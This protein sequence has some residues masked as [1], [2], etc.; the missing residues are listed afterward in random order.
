[1]VEANDNKKARKSRAEL[2]ENPLAPLRMGFHATMQSLLPHYQ[3]L[4]DMQ[5]DPTVKKDQLDAYKQQLSQAADQVF[6]EHQLEQ[7]FTQL[8][9]MVEADHTY[10]AGRFAEQCE[11]ARY[12]I[13]HGELPEDRW[14]RKP[15]LHLKESPA[16]QLVWAATL[17]YITLHPHVQEHWPDEHR[18][19]DKWDVASTTIWQDIEETP[20]LQRE[21]W[22]HAS[23]IA[24]NI[25]RKNTRVRWG[26]P[27]TSVQFDRQTETIDIDLIEALT[28]GVEHARAPVYREIGLSKLKIRWSERANE[29]YE[30]GEALKAKRD[31]AKKGQG[32]KPT[33][34]EFVEYSEMV[35]EFGAL[36]KVEYAAE[37]N[38][39]NQYAVERSR[40]HAND[41]SVNVVQTMLD[42]LSYGPEA[43]GEPQGEKADIAKQKLANVTRAMRMAFYCDNGLFDNTP[44][45]WK[46]VGVHPEWIEEDPTYRGA[47]GQTSAEALARIQQLC[48]QIAQAQPKRSAF[49]DHVEQIE[50]HMDRK[51]VW[52]MELWERYAKQYAEKLIEQAKEQAQQQMDQQNQQQDN[53]DEGEEQDQQ[54][55][56]QPQD[57][58]PQSGQGQSGS[59][60]GQQQQE[61][62]DSWP[63]EGQDD[64]KQ[65]PG[66]M[67]ETPPELGEEKGQD[68]EQGQDQNGQGQDGEGQDSGDQDGQSKNQQGQ[69]GDQRGKTVEELLEEMRE[70]EQGQEQDGQQQ[71]QQQG[72]DGDGQDGEG[73]QPGQ[74]GQE[75]QDGQGMQPGQ[76][77][78][79][80]GSQPGM[81]T[82]PSDQGGESNS[83]DDLPVGD[84]SNYKEMK[85]RYSGVI[86]Q[87]ERYLS[88]LKKPYRE[89]SISQSDHTLV[90]IGGQ[91]DRFNPKQVQRRREKILTRQQVGISDFEDFRNDESVENYVQDDVVIVVDFSS[92]MQGGNP[93]AGSMALQAA[94]IMREAGKRLGVDVKIFAFGDT[95]GPRVLVT[96]E[97]SDRQVGENLAK[98]QEKNNWGTKLKPAFAG[99]A[100]YPGINAV[101]ADRHNKNGNKMVG[102]THLL[103]ISDGDLNDKEEALAS[104]ENTLD[105]VPVMTTD[106][107][108]VTSKDKKTSMDE[109]ADE[110]QVKKAWQRPEVRR[111]INPEE[112]QKG[113]LDMLFSRIRHGARRDAIR[114]F[115]KTRMFDKAVKTA[116]FAERP[117][118][119]WTDRT[120]QSQTEA[121]RAR[122]A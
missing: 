82:M 43:V 80:P 67:D 9:R 90:P 94:C 68:S 50:A 86:R 44:A 105:A 117:Q 108:I 46:S 47:T 102:G 77:G 103:I 89:D 56:G 81:M 23:H 22:G 114:L 97:M 10:D 7:L 109:M 59:Q 36:I 11:R 51:N 5:A 1:M 8:Q 12:A 91:I 110:I 64:E 21:L 122:S 37:S 88:K 3:Q 63:I 42:H 87:A 35:A 28:T 70:Q 4:R 85:E 34:A 74:P 92:S 101:L 95:T 65:N 33:E 38:N 17:A 61:N 69:D 79:Q 99:T 106:W 76:P 104:V 2:L 6:G 41:V 57:G 32:P 66:D 75:G 30:R 52:V 49:H 53:G 71:D 93:S 45:G 72:Q 107:M 116:E 14:G 15:H 100:E 19:N 27:G 83:L 112:V 13:R 55:D 25:G 119:N 58:Q 18:A 113:I 16:A 20:D 24:E 48:H 54:Q 98:I 73:Q 118:H 111:A 62:D 31:A 78:G 120:Q 121:Q 26:L 84:W 115:E 40:T 29:L 96:P 39:A 60:G